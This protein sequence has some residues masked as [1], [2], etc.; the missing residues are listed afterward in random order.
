MDTVEIGCPPP[1]CQSGN[2][3]N[4]VTMTVIHDSWV[5]GVVPSPNRTEQTA[6]TYS[7][8]NCDLTPTNLGTGWSAQFGT[9]TVTS[10]GLDAPTGAK[11]TDSPAATPFTID[12]FGSDNGASGAYTFWNGTRQIGNSVTEANCVNRGAYRWDVAATGTLLLSRFIT[13]NGVRTRVDVPVTIPADVTCL[14]AH[15]DSMLPCFAVITPIL[16]PF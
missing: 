3:E 16:R 2:P 4:C 8:T 9:L 13:V 1:A 11:M 10:V 14:P 12:T 7:N 15:D 5:H 6:T